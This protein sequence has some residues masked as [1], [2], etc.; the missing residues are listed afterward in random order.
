M[1][2]LASDF[3]TDFRITLFISGYTAYD[4]ETGIYMRRSYGRRR[5][6]RPSRYFLGC[7]DYSALTR[8]EQL[9]AWP[10]PASPWKEREEA[11]ESLPRVTAYTDAEAVGKVN[12]WL[13][14]RAARPAA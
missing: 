14:A 10:R 4:P 12:R 8:P 5:G 7:L 9:A 6:G 11:G 13:E 3:D 1:L 2:K